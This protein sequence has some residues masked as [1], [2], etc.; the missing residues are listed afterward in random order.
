[1]K[2]EEANVF[3]VTLLEDFDKKHDN[4]DNKNSLHEEKLQ[5]DIEPKKDNKK[6]SDIIKNQ[7]K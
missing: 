5:P 6:Q 2:V 3:I 1:M 4:P 7:L